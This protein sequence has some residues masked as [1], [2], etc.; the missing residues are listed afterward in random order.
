MDLITPLFHLQYAITTD[1]HFKTV[2]KQICEV[3]SSIVLR[4][5]AVPQREC[6]F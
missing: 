5:P 1:C 3:I 4:H 6:M 2:R